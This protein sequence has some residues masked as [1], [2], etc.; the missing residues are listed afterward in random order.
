VAGGTFLNS[1]PPS[2][3]AFLVLRVCPAGVRSD[4]AALGARP[5]T[6]TCPTLPAARKVGVAAEARGVAAAIKLTTSETPANVA[7]T[8]ALRRLVS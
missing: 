8:R 7:K 6:Y 1:A 2:E 5:V 3:L 4:T